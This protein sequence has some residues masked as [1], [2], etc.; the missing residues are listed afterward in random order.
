MTD[1]DLE[2]RIEQLFFEPT[3]E[4]GHTPDVTAREAEP[5]TEESGRPVEE[6]VVSLLASEE[7]LA[8]E[9]ALTGRTEAEPEPGAV[10]RMPLE[11]PPP[12]EPQKP[13]AREEVKAAI[14][15]AGTG[16]L[17]RTGRRARLLRILQHTLTALGGTL[18]VLMLVRLVWVEPMPWSGSQMLYF[19]AFSVA[20]AIT[21]AQWMVNTSY[22]KSLRQAERQYGAAARSQS[23]LKQRTDELA[24]ANAPLQKRVLQLQTAFQIS[25]EIAPILDDV[26]ELVQ[27]A[28]QT[29]SERFDLQHVNLFLVDESEQWAVLRAAAGNTDRHML[30]RGYRV[31]VGDPSTVGQCTA[32]AEVCTAPTTGRSGARNGE[33]PW[34]GIPPAPGPAELNRLTRDTRSEIAL[35][36]RA[37][38]RVIGAL[39]VESTERDPF[40]Q[41]DVAI[42]QTVADQIAVA[43]ENAQTFARARARFAT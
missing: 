17:P 8:I 38:G 4:A 24:T 10:E 29:V 31:E 16:E 25:Q 21:W 23:I 13:S 19:A 26:D 3:A 11:I 12:I 28:A 37:G 35:P 42:L 7:S 27:R 39:K 33:T 5:E 43:V 41:E 36:M 30:V 32:N 20:I 1:Q 34:L 15:R 9:E 18:L 14:G 2:S 6:T 40:S 22:G